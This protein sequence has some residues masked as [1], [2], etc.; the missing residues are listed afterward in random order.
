MRLLELIAELEDEFGIYI[1]LN[2]VPT[3][4]TVGQVGE[5]VAALLREQGRQ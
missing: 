3:I 2:Q 5:R 1:P 4:R